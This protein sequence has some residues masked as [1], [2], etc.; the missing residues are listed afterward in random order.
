MTKN[1]LLLLFTLFSFSAIHAEEDWKLEN[2]TLT[3]SGTRMP[4]YLVEDHVPWFNDRGKINK[5]VIKDGVTNIGDFAFYDCTS[6]TS[7]TIP[8]SVKS[9]G[10]DAFSGCI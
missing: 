5:V 8:N 3:I 2:G 4:N 9:I 7:I 1:I 10:Y 6:L